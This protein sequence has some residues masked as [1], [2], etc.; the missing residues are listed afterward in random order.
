[1]LV[2]GRARARVRTSR[3]APARVGAGSRITWSSGN[4]V[5]ACKRFSSRYFKPRTRFG[6]AARPYQFPCRRELAMGFRA[7]FDGNRARQ[8][9]TKAARVHARGGNNDFILAADRRGSS[10]SIGRGPRCLL[11]VSRS[12]VLARHPARRLRGRAPTCSAA[13]L[14]FGNH[15]AVRRTVLFNVGRRARRSCPTKGITLAAGQATGGEGSPRDSRCS[16]WACWFNVG[17][18]PEHTAAT[19]AR[20]S[21]RELA[22]RER[23]WAPSAVG[24]SVVRLMIAGRWGRVGHLFPGHRD[25]RR[26][27]CGGGARPARAVR[28]VGTTAAAHRGGAVLPEQGWDLEHDRRL[29]PQDRSAQLGGRAAGCFRLAARR[30]CG[31]ARRGGLEGVSG[32]DAVIG[33]PAVTRRVRVVLMGERLARQSR[34]AICEQKLDS[35]ASRTRSSDAS[36]G[37][38]FLRRFD[39]T[40]P[41]FFQGP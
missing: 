6:G 1:M 34:P 2:H 7:A 3:F 37:R 26:R 25:S 20:E 40:A 12:F 4:A 14:A 15:A 11:P 33:R 27:S 32:P 36:C 16:S 8:T 24:Y 10:A 19:V 18:R 41:A 35:R 39:E 38:V 30:C 31:R 21:R 17:R 29:G 22:K 28:F 5:G 9:A 23:D 13:I